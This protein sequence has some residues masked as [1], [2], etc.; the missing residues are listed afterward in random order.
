MFREYFQTELAYLRELGLEFARANP[1][2]T[3]IF[4]ERGGDPDVQRLLEGFAFL[5][6]R[7]RER[8]NDAIPEVV[9]SL[10]RLLL[11]HYLRSIPAFSVVEFSPAPN[12]LRKRHRLA[13]GTEISSRPVGATNCL[14][15]TTADL[16][17]LPLSIESTVVEEPSASRPL[18]RLRF[19]SG[20]HALESVIAPG[21]IPVYLHGPLAQTATLHL[22]FQRYLID[23][24]YRNAQG[25][26]FLIESFRATPLS[27]QP[28]FGLLPWPDR[29][30]E[31]PRLLQEY[32][33]LPQKMLF[34]RFDGL[35]SIP[36][37]MATERFDLVFR[38]D[39]PPELAER[40][41][42]GTFRLN[43][44]PVVNL[45]D[46]DADPIRRDDCMKEYLL[47]VSGFDQLHSDVYSVQSVMGIRGRGRKRIVYTPFVDFEHAATEP[48]NRAYYTLRS[49][50]S[51]I[52][53]MLDTYISVFAPAAGD[54]GPVEETLSIELTGTNRMLAAALRTGDISLATPRSPA[55]ASF[56]NLP[57]VTVPVCPPVG[58]ELYWRLIAYLAINFPSLNDRE[59]LRSLLSLY[60]FHDSVR[61]QQG[62][63]NQLR[64]DAIRRVEM[65]PT[66]R[67][68]GDIPLLGIATTLEIEEAQ[69]A[70]VGDA[71]L[72]GCTLD[73]L[74]A[75]QVPIN[76]FNQLSVQLYP[77][78]T[79]LAWPPRNGD[80]PIL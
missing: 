45:F 12:A 70:S 43:C 65:K 23:A 5:S 16:D 9:E 53:N 38:F 32:F 34:L 27:L 61:Q 30:P 22:W 56:R 69:F 60:N 35:Q 64:V 51:P 67:L 29:S 41:E 13:R 58:S 49:V 2:L 7:I 57:G 42:T 3:D 20:A 14:F 55:F 74:F 17:L 71:F 50:Q 31:G 37:A 10:A 47:R 80:Q 19:R 72:F 76:S 26:S 6:A 62:R 77:S 54:G 4:S 79:V 39:R 33:A 68:L 46:T 24:T 18:I 21:G 25:Q 78:S 75:A 48:E 63:A 11:P 15:R 44:V 73:S 40:I 1:E 66:K 59:T 28:D 52:D 36:L 8:I